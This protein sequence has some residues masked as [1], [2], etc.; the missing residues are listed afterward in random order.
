MYQRVLMND[1]RLLAV[2][3]VVIKYTNLLTTS[4]IHV[5]SGAL[6]VI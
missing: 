6:G 2:L 1:M 3:Q 4:F 5:T